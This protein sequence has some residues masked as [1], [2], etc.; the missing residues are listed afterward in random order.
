MRKMNVVLL[1]FFSFAG[2][3]KYFANLFEGDIAVRDDDDELT[4]SQDAFLRHTSLN[5][6]YNHVPYYVDENSIR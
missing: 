2:P 4:S 6:P 1:I 3:K 5:W